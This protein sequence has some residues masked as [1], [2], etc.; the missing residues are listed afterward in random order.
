MMGYA[1]ESP[2]P[3]PG[4]KWSFQ[5]MLGGHLNLN[6]MKDEQ[7]SDTASLHTIFDQTRL[8]SVGL[9]KGQVA[10]YSWVTFCT[11]ESVSHFDDF[12]FKVIDK[13]W[14]VGGSPDAQSLAV[15]SS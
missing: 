12:Y 15:S 14:L 11:D 2:I 13:S 5:A 4:V 7:Q 9:K 1:A 6:V 10:G 8:D 3:T